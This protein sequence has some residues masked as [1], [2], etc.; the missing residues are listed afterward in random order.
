MRVN[1]YLRQPLSRRVLVAAAT[2]A[3]I[4]TGCSRGDDDDA[5]ST[6]DAASA[7]TSS[8]VSTS[9]PSSTTPATTEPSSTSARP[10]S[11]P[12]TTASRATTAPPATTAPGGATTTVAAAGATTTTASPG[13]AA[14]TTTTPAP[15]QLTAEALVLRSDG[16]GPFAF[17]VP[18]DGLVVRL[19]PVLGEPV[20]DETLEY[21]LPA[22]GGFAVDEFG[23][24]VFAHRWSRSTCFEN[25]L[26]VQFGGDAEANVT[27]VGWIYGGIGEL[28]TASGVTTESRWADFP[29]MTVYEGG[30]FSDGTGTIEGIDLS[31]ASDGELFADFD[32]DGNMIPGSPDPADVF[33]VELRS[34]TLPVYPFLDC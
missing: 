19:A 23:D 14:T 22:E 34:G 10:T 2:L 17:G 30:C 8:A 25:G 31:L 18:A 21:P 20:I 27:F 15:A 7:S 33:V 13:G 11:T 26:C 32:D 9:T 16:L 28:A 6:T 5:D 12:V 29:A 3:V 24:E 1:T 4:A